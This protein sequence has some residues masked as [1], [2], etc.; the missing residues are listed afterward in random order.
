MYLSFD[1]GPHPKT[2]NFILDELKRF[3]AKASFFCV[4]KNVV[5]HPDIYS[6]IITE[7]HR[8]GNH[9]HDHLNGWKVNDEEYFK[10][11]AAAAKYIDSFIF[12]PPYGRITRFQA[13]QVMDKFNFEIIMWSVLSGDFDNRI[14]PQV[15]W[16][17]VFK[18]AKP[19]S[20]IVFHDSERAMER[21][22]FAFTKT[23]EYYR[24]QGYA[25]DKIP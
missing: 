20:I 4:G 25:F 18:A 23:L 8:V 5:A 9:T 3:N 2:T 17:N 7:G 6:R 19:G 22:S 16:Q 13:K 12:R 1:D 24:D 11:I 15:C 10:N 21:M 14:S